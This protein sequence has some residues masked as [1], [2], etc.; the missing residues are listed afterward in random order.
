MATGELFA[1]STRSHPRMMK[2][3]SVADVR[4]L[5]GGTLDCLSPQEAPRKRGSGMG[6]CR[7]CWEGNYFSFYFIFCLSNVTNDCSCAFR[8]RRGGKERRWQ[9]HTGR[10]YFLFLC[11]RWSRQSAATVHLNGVDIW[12]KLGH[13]GPNALAPPPDRTERRSSGGMCVSTGASESE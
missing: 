8:G 2:S 9:K 11:V 10:F 4:R 3:N 7:E 6:L 12:R 5:R 1:F 13:A